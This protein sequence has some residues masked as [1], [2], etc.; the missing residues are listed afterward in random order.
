MQNQK[1]PD[2]DALAPTPHQQN[3]SMK[4]ANR[5]SNR[6]EALRLRKQG[7]SFDMI[8][9]RLGVQGSTASNWVR[10]AIRNAPIEDVEDVR[11]LELERLDMLLAGNFTSAVRGD[12][13][14]GEFVLKVME[15]RAKYLNLDQQAQA[16][17]QEV[18]N[19]LDRLVFGGEGQGE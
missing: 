13:R 14:A 6:N 9:A 19:L 18:G 3:A 4:R 1:T 11:S 5:A 15:R 7:L 17:L 8:G 12:V 2:P 10:E 16:G